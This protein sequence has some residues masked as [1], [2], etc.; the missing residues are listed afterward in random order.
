MGGTYLIF[1]G[2]GTQAV[3]H[4]AWVVGHLDLTLYIS[5]I[6]FFVL[7]KK[8]V[9]PMQKAHHALLIVHCKHIHK[10]IELKKSTCE[11]KANNHS[12]FCIYLWPNEETKYN[13]G[14][15]KNEFKAVIEAL[16][17]W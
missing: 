17:E 1:A 4:T 14:D 8:P 12:P 5:L 11:Q 15:K 7:S 2:G 16:S 3:S 13:K 6:H 10:K 9:K